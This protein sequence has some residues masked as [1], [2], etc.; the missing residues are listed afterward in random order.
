MSKKQD[1]L[2]SKKIYNDFEIIKNG[3]PSIL[4]CPGDTRGLTSS[5]WV[6]SVKG[7]SFK[8]RAWYEHGSVWKTY[9]SKEGKKARFD[10][11][12]ALVKRLFPDVELVKSPFGGFVPKDDLDDAMEGYEEWLKSGKEN[13]DSKGV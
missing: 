9:G 8:D 10:E 6:V 4:C 2:R 5:R 13:K 1:F 12:I 3:H 7:Q 11:A